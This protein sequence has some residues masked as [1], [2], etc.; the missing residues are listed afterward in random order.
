MV[1]SKSARVRMPMA[2]PRAWV[3]RRDAK[4][5]EEE[6]ELADGMTLVGYLLMAMIFTLVWLVALVV[7]ILRYIEV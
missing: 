6:R 3:R 4:L 5:T 7:A 1:F 2:W